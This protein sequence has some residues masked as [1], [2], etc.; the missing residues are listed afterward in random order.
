MTLLFSNPLHFFDFGTIF[1][2]HGWDRRDIAALFVL[3]DKF[4]FVL[5]FS[6]RFWEPS[7]SAIFP[8][9][10]SHL[11]YMI[12]VFCRPSYQADSSFLR[13]PR[14]FRR[15]DN[16]FFGYSLNLPRARNTSH[17]FRAK[18][19]EGNPCRHGLVCLHFLY[20][21]TPPKNLRLQSVSLPEL[22]CPAL[23]S[24]SCSIR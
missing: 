23:Q 12:M 14:L 21:Q 5:F 1:P 17:L 8:P 22:S 2:F 11:V 4:M 7:L 15:R 10:C 16:F 24:L 18:S 3:R 19:L 6:T 9:V 13:R 20:P